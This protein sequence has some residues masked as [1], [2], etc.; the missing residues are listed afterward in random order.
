[1]G[2]QFD[3]PWVLLLLIPLAVFAVFALRGPARISAFRHRL[4]AALRT[5]ALLLLVLLLAGVQLYTVQR[6]H[7]VVYAVDRSSSTESSREDREWIGDSL[8][9]KKAEDEFAVISFGR[10]ASAEQTMSGEAPL[11]GLEAAVDPDY[12]NVQRAL[13]LASGMLGTGDPR[14]VLI[15]DGAENVGSMLEAGRLLKN[16]GITVDVLEKETGAE[17]DAAI[18]SLSLPGKLYLGEAFTVEA[19]LRSTFSGTGEIRLYEDNVEIGSQTVRVERG[20]SSV[21]LQGLAK[22]PGLHRYRAELSMPGDTQSANNAAFAFTRVEGSPSVLIVE[23]KPD[24]SANIA[25]ALN[26]GLIETTVI[27]P[28]QMPTQLADYARYDSILFNNVSG[29]SLGQA[30]MDAI[31]T[32]V[33]SYGIGFMMSGGDQSFGLGGYFDTPIERALPVS[34][35]LEGK[36]EIPE[37]G[38]ILVIDRSGSMAGSKIELAKEAAMRTVELMRAKDTVG[39]VAFDDHPWWVVEPQKLSDKEEVLE[40]IQSI[41]SGGGTNIYPAMA[42]ATESILEI[43]AQRRHI[44]LMTDGQSAGGGNYEELISGLLEKNV[45]VSSVAVGSDADRGLLQNIAN[46]GKGRFYD[47]QDETTLPAIFSREAVLLARTYVVD[48]PFTPAVADAGDWTSLFAD[49]LP[50]LGGYVATSAKPSAQTA[51]VSPEPDPLLVR[52]QYGSGRS[53]AWTSDLTGKWSADWV[54]WDK[55]ANV[56]T[57]T[58]KWTF[59][60]FST[61]PYRVETALGEGGMELTVTA[62]QSGDAALPD[63]L[64]ASIGGDGGGTDETASEPIT[65]VQTSPGRYTGVLPVSEPGAYLLNLSPAGAGN[66]AEGSSESGASGTDQE[67]AGSPAEG[68]GEN[69]SVENDSVEADS[70]VN[71][72]GG[73]ETSGLPAATGTGLVIPYSPEYRI[74]TVSDEGSARLAELARLTGGRTLS[75]EDPAAV[76]N[77]PAAPH[78]QMRDW[79]SILL[80]AVLAL[81]IADVAVRRLAVPWERLAAAL[82]LPFAA[83]RRR[84]SGAAE[85]EAAPAEKGALARLSS[86]KR[87]STAFRGGEKHAAAGNAAP[88]QGAAER[89]AQRPE[90]SPRAEGGGTGSAA[91][92]GIASAVDRLRA[93]RGSGR[94]AGAASG[95]PLRGAGS[96][97]SADSAS[98]T[99]SANSAGSIDSAKLQ[100]DAGSVQRAKLHGENGADNAKRRQAADTKPHDADSSKRPNPGSDRSGQ[101]EGQPPDSSGEAGGSAMDRLLAAK[102]RSSR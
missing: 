36:R 41:P 73:E 96:A 98:S 54:S 77:Q 9:S 52:W 101:S 58:V 19:Q 93:E 48:K 55:F 44:I 60:Q 66:A 74:S 85:G 76:Y 15:S 8:E 14:I 68:S 34:M 1:M 2:V 32:A 17:R 22:R 26:A 6:Q 50:Q 81:W 3:H 5:L 30:K 10:A 65:L 40:Q 89:P 51:L 99:N 16:R 4:A 83:A 21:L 24:T 11:G 18:D 62:S 53:V 75:W 87:R 45:T 59:P 97:N 88:P 25:K 91:E 27:S 47:V 100:S 80:A 64:I 72:A 63:E 33:R 43:G 82:A 56:L 84:S 12:T 61:S 38:L 23:G 71:G 49:G 57:Q 37:L 35:E 70:G 95:A 79:T 86:A 28:G 13:Q 29:D 42:A 31:E 90:E 46:L 67:D 7:E 69:D 94:N 39:V 20:E 92:G 102:K 78:K